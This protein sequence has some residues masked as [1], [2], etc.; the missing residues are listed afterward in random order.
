MS[1]SGQILQAVAEQYGAALRMLEDTIVNCNDT[2]WLDP[3]NKPVISQVVYHTLYFVDIYLS[4]NKSEWES[5]RGKLGEDGDADT[6][7]HEPEKVFT[8]QELQE[9]VKEIRIKAFTLFTGLT[10]SEL[11]GIPIFEWHGSTFLSSLL[12][13]LRHI[14]HHVGSLHVRLNDSSKEPLKWFSKESLV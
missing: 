1:E 5:F 13:N 10:M 4:K 9:Y 14:M 2:L 8:K 7:I 12:Y 11:N 6:F 3:N